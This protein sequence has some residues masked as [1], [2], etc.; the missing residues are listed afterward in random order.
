MDDSL[1]GPDASGRRQIRGWRAPGRR[2]VQVAA[3]LLL[4]VRPLG[5]AYVAYVRWALGSLA[6]HTA[7]H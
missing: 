4:A 6:R 2:G 1:E 5:L 7:G 3:A